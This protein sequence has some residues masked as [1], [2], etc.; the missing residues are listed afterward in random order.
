METSP[1]HSGSHSTTD[2]DALERS[3]RLMLLAVV[4][5]STLMLLPMILYGIIGERL[6]RML[7][8]GLIIATIVGAL[9]YV[10]FM[11][12]FHRFQKRV[13]SDPDLRQRMD[14]ERVLEMRKEAIYRGWMI[15][16]L[17]IGLGVSVAP[18]VDLPAQAVLL[19][20]MLVAVNMPILFFL[21]LDRR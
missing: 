5:T 15:L 9:T 17:V 18:F 20:L 4:A 10:V 2:I 3:R 12:R 7:H 13:L 11:M 19:A 16:V 6:P 1:S 8:D 14:D 21:D